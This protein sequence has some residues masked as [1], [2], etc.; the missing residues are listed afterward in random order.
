MINTPESGCLNKLQVS[1]MSS[2]R[3][4]PHIGTNRLATRKKLLIG[5]FPARDSDN[6]QHGEF[7]SQRCAKIRLKSFFYAKRN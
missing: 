2:V 6:F 4:H 1:S 5:N 7:G 3:N